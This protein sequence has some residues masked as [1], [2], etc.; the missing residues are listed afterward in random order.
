MSREVNDTA[1]VASELEAFVVLKVLV[2][3]IGEHPG[4]VETVDR[5]EGVL[6]LGYPL[7]NANGDVAGQL[8]FEVIGGREVIGVGVRLSVRCISGRNR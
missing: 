4:I 8:R 5:G 2:K 6:D 3:G 1:F 7:A